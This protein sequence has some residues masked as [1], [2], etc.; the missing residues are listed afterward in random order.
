MGQAYNPYL[1][2]WEYIPDGEPHVFG[3]RVYLYGSHD[4]FRG[5]VYCMGNYKGWS[6]PVDDLSDWTCSGVI[7]RREQ[8]P[9]N[10]DAR[11]TLFAP[12]AVQGPDGRYYLYYIPNRQRTVSVA[13]CDEPDGNFHFYGY[14][15][16]EDGTRLGERDGDDPQFDPGVYREGDNTYLYTGFCMIQDTSRKGATAT[17]LGTDMLTI[18]QD[19]VVIA[20][21]AYRTPGTSFEGHA[22]FE[23]PSMRRRGDTYYFIYSSIH[24]REL[25]YAT[26]QSPLGPFTYGGVIIDNG[27]VGIGSYKPANR[28]AAV[29]CNNHGSIVEIQGQWYVFY[30]RP[31]NGNQF[32]RQAC[33]EPITFD[34]NG[35]IAQVE[36]TSCGLN[37][38]PLDGRAWY[39][40]YIACNLFNVRDDRWED[41]RYRP[42][43]EQDG[44]DGDEMPGYVSNMVDG[45]TAAFKHLD[46]HGITQIAIRARG[47]MDG[48]IE[49][50]TNP[51][52]AVYASIPIHETNGWELFTAPCTI[53]DGVHAIYLTHN[54]GRTATL[55]GFQLS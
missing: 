9:D 54:G 55:G 49:L 10:A 50:R 6:A 33:A 37:G 45:G 53:P 11:S 41:E 51:Y 29:H 30:H 40:A 15:H 32:S 12:D 18:T 46:C 2:S 19:P 17:V 8:D 16:Y 52:G 34:E 21:P 42:I 48:S 5:Y 4:H 36:M 38:G 13:V 23:A 22:F 1:P 28:L 3:D 7:Y 26:G 44:R 24:N 25:C 35:H 31:T 14:V 43:I 27:D 47:Y 20:P 39:D